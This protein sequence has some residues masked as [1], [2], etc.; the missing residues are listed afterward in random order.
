MARASRDFDFEGGAGHILSG[1]LE[2]PDGTP[3]AVAI[4]SHCFTCSKDYFAS[5]RVSRGLAERGY[6]VLRFDFTGLGGS[7]GEFAES[8]FSTNVAD[9]LAAAAALSVEVGP[10]SL[11]VGHSLGGTASIVAAGRL[12]SVRAVAT[13]NSPF[14]P[15]HL[16]RLIKGKEAEMESTGRVMVDVGNRL[17]PIT[18]GFL[19]D[20]LSHD[21][22]GAIGGLGRPL[23][24]LHDPADTV[25]PVA[26][27]DE[28]LAAARH[29]KSFVSLDGVGHLIAKRGDAEQAAGI[30]ASWA[31]RALRLPVGA[32]EGA[33]LAIREDGVVVVREEIGGPGFRTL[34][35]AGR[36]LMAADE[37]ESVGGADSGPTPHQML[38]GALGA[39]TAITLRLYAKRKSWGLQRVRVEVAHARGPAGEDLFDRRLFLEGD[40]DAEQRAR[41]LEI[42]EKCPVHK[43]L[44]GNSRIATVLAD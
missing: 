12:P 6:A 1:K 14:G 38:Q 36:H 10:P 16:L 41:L 4:F 11:L 9:I 21:M 8:T 27:A 30:V 25:A 5:V 40:L 19:E 7:R 17:M 29:P 42:A 44:S 15:D 35:R 23:L 22:A 37:P 2:L 26:N 20:A 28:I 34:V 13:L 43:A 33:D 32:E 31:D 18:R 24:V 3:K 39:C